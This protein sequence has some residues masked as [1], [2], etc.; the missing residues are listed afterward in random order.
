MVLFVT[1]LYVHWSSYVV[2]CI[3]IVHAN[4]QGICNTLKHNTDTLVLALS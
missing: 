3:I 1:L 4:K 2:K